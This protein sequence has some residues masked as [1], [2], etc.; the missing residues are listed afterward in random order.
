MNLSHTELL[1]LQNRI[2]KVG[3]DAFIKEE[4]RLRGVV[5]QTRQK[6][7]DFTDD[8]AKESYIADRKKEDEVRSELRTLMWAA[9]KTK[10]IAY[11]GDGIFWDDGMGLDFFD[12]YERAERIIDN[13]V[14]AL[15]TLEELLE[16]L[17]EAVPELD[18]PML[19]W[20]CYHRDVA[21][22]IHYRAFSIPKKSGGRRHIWAPMPKLK[23]MQSWILENILV[24]MPVHEAAHGFIQGRSIFSNAAVHTDSK[25]ILSMDLKNFFPTLTFPRVKGLF[26]AMGY[27]AGVATL[28]AL[29]CTESPRRPICVRDPQSGEEKWVYVAVGPRCLPQG[30]P[31]S[32]AITNL[33]CV[34]LD[35]RLTGLCQKL[36]IRYTRYADDLTFSVSASSKKNHD[37]KWLEEMVTKIVNSEGFRVHP[38]KVGTMGT[39]TSQRVTG[40]V[41]N[42]PKSPRVPRTL[43]QW[44]RAAIHNQQQGKAFHENENWETL[45]GY[46]SF[47]FSAEPEKGTHLLQALLALADQ[48]EEGEA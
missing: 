32:P 4:F 44:L 33:A 11:L 31:A 15:E 10:N 38:D 46:A 21:E 42:G 9:Y 6:I 16:A 43:K 12:P 13:D 28:L 24:R 45:M 48:Q 35:R 18:A 27:R 30:S 5:V 41:V 17:A 25:I 26:R 29:I 23:A 47:V 34:R 14:P 40:L 7:K 8:K 3:K 20:F 36:G 1:A 39:G 37:M 19:R 2:E 22:T